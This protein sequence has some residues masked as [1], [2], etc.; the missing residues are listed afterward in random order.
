MLDR[1]NISLL[2]NVLIYIRRSCVLITSGSERT[3]RQVHLLFIVAA[4][5]VS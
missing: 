5:W 1:L 2:D 3:K 4:H